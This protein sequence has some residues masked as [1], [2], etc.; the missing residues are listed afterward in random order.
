MIS[1]NV[2]FIKSIEL[3]DLS[4]C[5]E[6]EENVFEGMNFH[7]DL[8]HNLRIDGDTGIGKSLLLKL[9]SG[10]IMPQKGDY[11]INGKGVQNMSFEEFTP[12]RL[13]MGYSF[14]FGGLMH[15]R[16]LLE[17]IILTAQY[18]TN[19]FRFDAEERA[20]ELMK[21]GGIYKNAHLRPS[22]VPGSH[23][24]MTILLRAF[25]TQ[26]QILLLDEPAA[27]L[28]QQDMKFIAQLIHEGKE[29]GHLKCVVFVTQQKEMAQMLT[30]K[31]IY[32]KDKR[33]FDPNEAR[34]Q[35]VG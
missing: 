28:S 34:L 24:K 13:G 16:T 17:N 35:E 6:G 15:N 8:N 22:M 9:L 30:E 31:I 10:L 23:R 25:L 27:G 20:L 26:P 33:I 29:E 5:F 2:E 19:Y 11:L 21:R 18:H 4:I 1:K 3:R 12:Y 14:E 7:F 32:I